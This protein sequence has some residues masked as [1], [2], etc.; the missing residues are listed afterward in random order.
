MLV[1][2][3]QL[4]PM[5]PLLLAAL[6]PTQLTLSNE[7]E[8]PLT[9]GLS[10]SGISSWGRRTI[11]TDAVVQAVVNTDFATPG[12]APKL[13]DTLAEKS[14]QEIAAGDDGSFAAEGPGKYICITVT[15]ETD[16]VMLLEASGHAVVYVNAQPRPGDPYSH[17]YMKVPLQLKKGEN[18]L[19]FAH[20]GRG[21]MKA[22]LTTPPADAGI[23]EGDITKGDVLLSE[24][25]TAQVIDNV[26][27]AGVP[28]YNATPNPIATTIT[29]T[30]NLEDWPSDTIVTLPPMS[31]TKVPVKLHH[32]FRD[33]ATDDSPPITC[34][35]IITAPTKTGGEAQVK[36]NTK[37]PTQIHSRTYISDIDASVQYLS[38]VPQSTPTESSNEKAQSPALVLSVH[39]ASVE[40]INQANSYSPKPDMVIACPTNRRPFGF[41]WEDW[42]RIDAL[43][44]LSFAQ[45]EFN[46]DPNRVYLTG[47]SM[48]G[49]GTWQLGVLY[50]E[51]FAAI[52][53]SAGWL[54][55]DSYLGAL[56]QKTANPLDGPAKTIRDARASSDTLDFFENLKGRG[57][58][59]LHGD[60]DDNVPVTEARA[61]KEKLVE[62]GLVEGTDFGYHEQP[63]AGHWWD[64]QDANGKDQPGAACVDWPEIFDTFRKNDLASQREAREKSLDKLIEGSAR[65][66]NPLDPRGFCKGSFKRAFDHKFLLIYATHGTPEENAWAFSKARYDAEQWWYRGNGYAELVSDDQL[67]SLVVEPDFD[68]RNLI[69]YGTPTSNAA[70][71]AFVPA[72]VRVHAEGIAFMT[73]HGGE[74]FEVTDQADGQLGMLLAFDVVRPEHLRPGDTPTYRTIA[75]VTGTSVQGC[76]T[77]DRLPIFLA[78]TGFPSQLILRSDVWTKG[79]E[80]IVYANL[81][82]TLP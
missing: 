11:N 19:L 34:D 38:I 51:Q 53:P 42:G 7:P 75:V 56:G 25:G 5:L 43:E 2:T 71:S 16:R 36:L 23:I 81:D 24:G 31:V 66:T 79:D 13:S 44:A 1:L 64:A 60:A 77:L 47:H 22:K 45:Q 73:T 52:A 48:G 69:I 27:F 29:A 54:S 26:L 14:W 8:L 72:H 50:P 55:F 6:L 35:L 58:Y 49:H 61:A 18:V 63:G 32:G 20:A 40:A 15:C 74:L 65:P 78:G 57:I 76:K 28:I 41:D 82:A 80:S 21:G 70:W 37:K 33:Y 62:M 68:S 30:V 39:G 10:I 4:S 17:G 3:L 12:H 59:I 46:T 9:R 67:S